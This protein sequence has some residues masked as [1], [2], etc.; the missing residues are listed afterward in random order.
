MQYC[1]F[2][3]KE[4]PRPISRLPAIVMPARLRYPPSPPGYSPAVMA[5]VRLPP[6]EAQRR[7]A[8]RETARLEA[9][10]IARAEDRQKRDELAKTKYL[11]AVSQWGTITAGCREARV[12]A[13]TIL[14]W[15]EHDLEFSIREQQAR[16]ALVDQLEE[17]ALRRGV[18]GVQRPVYQAGHLVGYQTEYSDLLLQLLLRANRP[19][20]YRE[21]ADINVTQVIKTVSGVSPADVL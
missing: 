3:V 4:F 16:E 5:N 15:R 1:I 20:K 10:K 2:G 14:Q 7:R 8:E 18:K 17:E 6:G 21:K 13:A 12:T 19:E 11:K 9:D